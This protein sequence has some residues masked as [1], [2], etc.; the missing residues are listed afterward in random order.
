MIGLA[1]FFFLLGVLCS[2]WCKVNQR[3][4]NRLLYGKMQVKEPMWIRPFL[5]CSGL[6]LALYVLAQFIPPTN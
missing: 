5:F 2:W 1:A 6:G 4:N 3:H